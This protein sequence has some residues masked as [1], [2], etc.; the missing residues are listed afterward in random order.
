MADKD[1]IQSC[2]LIVLIN[3]KV[4]GIAL[5]YKGSMPCTYSL[6]PCTCWLPNAMKCLN[7][8]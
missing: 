6:I 5:L 4:P 1:V 7:D 3:A 2:M 8:M